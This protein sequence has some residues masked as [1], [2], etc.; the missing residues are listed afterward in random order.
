MY[1]W[2]L[3]IV[4]QGAKHPESTLSQPKPVFKSRY[5]DP[6]H[7]A[8]SGNFRALLT[9][10]KSGTQT[11]SQPPKEVEKGQIKNN[12]LGND[13]RLEEKDSGTLV[14]HVVSS[15]EDG[16]MPKSAEHRSGSEVSPRSSGES[17]VV[18]DA[19]GG[20]LTPVKKAI[21]SVSS[22]STSPN[23][24][25]CA[26]RMLCTCSSSICRLKRRW[27]KRKPRLQK[28]GKVKCMKLGNAVG[29]QS[30]LK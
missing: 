8:A 11:S 23:K 29:L 28:Q 22:S 1:A 16:K 17:Q 24:Y 15:D 27:L 19:R 26:A 2:N 3:L 4:Q 21:K 30:K 9:G 7:P 13:D 18:S 25:L 10:G 5:A 12:R 6:T 20:F 14:P